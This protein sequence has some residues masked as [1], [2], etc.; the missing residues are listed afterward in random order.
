MSSWKTS[1]YKPFEKEYDAYLLEQE[2]VAL[3][4]SAYLLIGINAVYI[5]IYFFRVHDF[6]KVLL[7]RCIFIA[8]FASMLLVPFSRLQGR[9]RVTILMAAHILILLFIFYMD[10]ATDVPPSF[11][12]NTII[13]Y[14]FCSFTITALRFRQALVLNL[15]SVTLFIIH[16]S[17]FCKTDFHVTQVPA[18]ISTFI[19]SAMVGYLLER[20]KRLNFI[21]QQEIKD[22]SQKLEKANN[23][24]TVILSI[25]SHDLASPLNSLAGLIEAR[26]SNLISA[27]EWELFVGKLS[28]MLTNTSSLLQNLVRWS[29]T[30]LD[31]FT[32]SYKDVLLLDLVEESLE[33]LNV[34]AQGK[35]ITIMRLIGEKMQINT[36]PDML[37]LVLRNVLSNA[38]KYS[39]PDSR[40][41]LG[42]KETPRHVEISI[43]DYGVGMTQTNQEKLFQDLSKSQPGTQNEK[44][45]GI[46]LLLTQSFISILGGDIEIESGPG[47]GTIIRMKLPKAK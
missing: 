35:N 40:I 11:L 15:G 18:I 20:S 43:R 25:L 8:I 28:H 33:A 6:L 41:E 7:I 26:N 5:L 2:R 14:G 4:F 24:K 1:F 27:E 47:N 39:F 17:V 21:Q 42:A 36:D 23:Q 32:P 3:R 22:Y 29:R 37:E 9:W 13:A 10:Y 16:L 34:T 38:I 19:L 31:G 30:Q 45:T 44:G 46:G 12:S